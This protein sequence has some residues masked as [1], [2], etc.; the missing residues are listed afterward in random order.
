MQLSKEPLGSGP[1]GNAGF[2]LIE[3][4]IVLV[5]IGLIIAAVLKGEDLINNGR[6]LNFVSNPVREAQTA[7]MAY[8]DRTGQYPDTVHGMDGVRTGPLY[9]M[10]QAG[11]NSVLDLNT[12]FPACSDSFLGIVLT[13]MKVQDSSGNIATYPVIAIQ[14]IDPNIERDV[15]PMLSWS[16]C[17][18][19]YATYLKSKIDGNSSDWKSGR[20]RMITGSM[21]TVYTNLSFEISRYDGSLPDGYSSDSTKAYDATFRFYDTYTNDDF[22]TPDLNAEQ[23]YTLIYFYDQQPH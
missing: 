11:I 12:P 4:A 9:N 2:T 8:Y 15:E 14:P 17:A 22:V 16:Q 21:E 18:L 6:M 7:A 19:N 20:V 10:Y 3:L 1:K 5:V 23:R 13:T